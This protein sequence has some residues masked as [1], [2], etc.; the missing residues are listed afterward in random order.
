MSRIANW[1]RFVHTSK[2]DED[3]GNTMNEAMEASM[4]SPLMR[5][6]KAEIMQINRTVYDEEK[7]PLFFVYF[8]SFLLWSLLL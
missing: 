8:S 3:F 1:S 4:G 5:Q 6:K 7:D 2:Q